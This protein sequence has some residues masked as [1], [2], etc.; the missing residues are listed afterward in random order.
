MREYQNKGTCAARRTVRTLRFWPNERSCMNCRPWPSTASTTALTVPYGEA[1]G[2]EGAAQC[3]A[4]STPVTGSQLVDRRTLGVA[5]QLVEE[6]I[7]ALVAV[8]LDNAREE[9]A[10]AHRLGPTGDELSVVAEERIDA[11]VAVQLDNARR[12]DHSRRR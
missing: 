6:R 2:G 8:Q 9:G 5:Q 11:L 7:D 3:R 1:R 12:S 10:A 4:R